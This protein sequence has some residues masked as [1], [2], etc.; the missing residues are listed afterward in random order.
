M[1][2]TDEQRQIRDKLREFARDRLAPNA[3]AWDREHT[4]PRDALRALGELGALGVVVPEAWG[5]AGLDYVCLA[6]ALEEIAAA[7][8]PVCGSVRQKQPRR[9]PRASGGSRRSFCA[10]VPNA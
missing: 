1:L 5:G 2:L 4:F 6:V 8:D 3:A 9:S 10:S 7:S